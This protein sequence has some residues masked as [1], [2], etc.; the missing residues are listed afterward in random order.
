[1]KDWTYTLP[2]DAE[3]DARIAE[4]LEEELVAMYRRYETL[5]E[6]GKTKEAADLKEYI[7][8]LESDIEVF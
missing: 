4:E 2:D 1:M 8:T 5:L 7:E 6:I 3:L